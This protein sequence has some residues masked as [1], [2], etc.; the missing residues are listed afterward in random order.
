MYVLTWVT[1]IRIGVWFKGPRVNGA[2]DS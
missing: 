1:L 2:C